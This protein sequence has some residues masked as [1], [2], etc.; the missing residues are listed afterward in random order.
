LFVPYITIYLLP[1]LKRMLLMRSATILPADVWP[2]VKDSWVHELK[3]N[4]RI[5]IISTSLFS[6]RVYTDKIFPGNGTGFAAKH[7]TLKEQIITIRHKRK[8]KNIIAKKEKITA[9][10]ISLIHRRRKLILPD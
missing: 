5:K 6:L 10:H 2:A 4:P 1:L 3:N 8:E 9:R 7:S